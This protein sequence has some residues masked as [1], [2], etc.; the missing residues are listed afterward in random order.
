MSMKKPSKGSTSQTTSTPREPWKQ[1]RKKVE[2]A[3]VEEPKKAAKGR[4][5]EREVVSVFF[6]FS[7]LGGRA[8]QYP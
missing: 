2:L 8:I 7:C 3:M 4:K 1:E 6:S 5:R